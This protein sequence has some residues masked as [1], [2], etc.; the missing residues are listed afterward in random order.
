MQKYMVKG[1]KGSES[2]VQT[3]IVTSKQKYIHEVVYTWQEDCEML[4]LSAVKAE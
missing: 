4:S 3:V 1:K 2:C